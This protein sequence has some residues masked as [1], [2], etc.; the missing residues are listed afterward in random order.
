MPDE[1]G[2]LVALEMVMK[3]RI[4]QKIV[5]QGKTMSRTGMPEQYI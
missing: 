2:R 1:D 5:E 3:K 4:K